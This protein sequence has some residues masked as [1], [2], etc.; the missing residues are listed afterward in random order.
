MLGT[1]LELRKGH[2]LGLPEF[3]GRGALGPSGDRGLLQEEMGSRSDN[4][5]GRATA[6]TRWPQVT[7]GI[8][9]G[10]ALGTSACG[11]ALVWCMGLRPK[12]PH[13]LGAPDLS[14]AGA[15]P[16]APETS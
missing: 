10:P 3:R 16:G 1:Q 8:R 11:R 6:A 14:M 13:F 2:F 4:R 5:K 9:V 12:A 15:Y 7:G